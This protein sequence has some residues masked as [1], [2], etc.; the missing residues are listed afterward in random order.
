M[1]ARTEQRD[2]M[3]DCDRPIGRE[4]SFWESILY[5]CNGETAAQA[6]TEAFTR[7]GLRVV[8]S[9]DLRSAMASHA[10][11]E[12]PHHG[13]AQCT[14]QFVVLL[15][16][17]DPSTEPALS[18]SKGSGGAPV[19]MTAHSRDAQA[20]VQIVRPTGML[21]DLK[22][23]RD[24]ANSQPD[25]RLVEQVMAALFEAALT[26]QA[27]LPHPAEVPADAHREA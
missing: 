27:V 8:R 6:A 1:G 5:D 12:C 14:C 24:D 19:V 17:G 22:A 2:A 10:D 13:T 21:R 4:A 3:N 11:C 7:R 16:Y 25:P 9:F 20:Q 26:V 18:L 23:V 15:V